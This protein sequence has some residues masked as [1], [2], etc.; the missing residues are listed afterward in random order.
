MDNISAVYYF[1]AEDTCEIF[2]GL[3]YRK[4]FVRRYICIFGLCRSMYA[5]IGNASVVL[6]GYD[7]ETVRTYLQT[8]WW[9]AERLDERRCRA[10]QDRI[11]R[12]GNPDNYHNRPAR[13][14]LQ[15]RNG[16]LSAVCNV[17]VFCHVLHMVRIKPKPSKKYIKVFLN[18]TKKMMFNISAGFRYRTV[19]AYRLS[20]CFTVVQKYI[21][22]AKWNHIFPRKIRL[23]S[24]TVL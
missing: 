22:T 12:Y 3:S 23:L 18:E 7:M 19:C 13:S 17:C 15:N 14:F 1:R 8:V 4:L 10:K 5:R 24:F 6:H 9:T 11:Q 2:Y 20:G 21:S 16:S